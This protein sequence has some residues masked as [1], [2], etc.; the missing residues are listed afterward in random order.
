MGFLAGLHGTVAAIL[1]C[2]LLTADEAGLPLP[3]APNEGLL[4]LTGVLISS[5]AFPLWAIFPAAF[6]AMTV[7]MLAGYGWARTIGQGGLQAIVMRVGATRVCE[8]ARQR[9]GPA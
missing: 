9:R 7:G 6:L 1:I 3:I 8:P 4:L 2:S 5:D